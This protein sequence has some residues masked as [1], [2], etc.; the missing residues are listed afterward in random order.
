MTTR[1]RILEHLRSH[2]YRPLRT[3]RLAR[4][5]DIAEEEYGEFRDLV[6]RLIREG[7]I[8]VGAGGKLLPPE[9]GP[10]VKETRR[11][12]LQGR[13]SQSA[14]GFG[15]VSPAE[16][17]GP[18]GKE[19]LF[20]PAGDSLDAVTGD[21]VLAQVTRKTA[22]GYTGRVLEVLQRG[23]SRYVGTY[24]E[25]EAGP[26]V[27]PDGGVL[28][29]DFAA[30]DARS[31]GAQPK[32][33]VVFEVLRYGLQ[34]E[35]GEAVI[36]EVLGHRGDPGVDT[37]VVIRQFDLP[38][39]FSQEAL[40]E[41]RQAAGRL[42]E[43]ALEGRRDLARETVIT[44]DPA[45]ARDF[46]DA[47][48]LADGGDGSQVLGVH[49]ADVAFFVP[50][51][52]ALDRDARERG[53]SV[54]LPTTVLPMLPEV[55]SNGVCS[56]QEGR[57]RLTKSVFIRFGTE[58]EVLDVDLANSTIRSA[59]RLTY[60]QA[61]AAMDGKADGLPRRVADL[62]GRME[63]L[64]RTLLERRRRQGYLE[65]DL[66][67]VDLE[68]DAEGRVVDAHPEDTSFSHKVIEMF[69]VEANEAVA[70]ELASRGLEF[71]RRIHPPPD[72]E[73]AEDLKHFAT[74]IGYRLHDAADRHALQALLNA[75][76][77]KPEAYGIHLAVLRSL[78]R[79]EYSPRPEGHFALASDAYCHFTSP[80]RRYPD[81]TV[82]R[83][84]DEIVAGRAEKGR[85]GRHRKRPAPA[86]PGLGDLARHAS[87]T[88]QRAEAAERELTKI[89]LL[90][91][92]Q[93]RIGESYTGV[94]TGVQAFG[95]FVEIPNLLVDGLVHI[96]ALKDD[97]YK[98]DK[99]RWALVGQRRGRALRVGT[100]FA[101]RIAAVDIPRRQ[102]DLQPAEAERERRRPGKAP[103]KR[104]P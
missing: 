12:L 61:Q 103:P 95:M 83:L 82:H 53:T 74:S 92:L 7:E 84:F 46:D 3:R 28:L 22:R 69:M 60:E 104:G 14:R 75:V 42:N 45:D 81:L 63:R 35:P 73:A 34:S 66:P 54:Y 33:K 67:E 58:G 68:F 85:G 55:L 43:A 17:S 36:T 51:G 13:F 79:A 20:I 70:R 56:L 21:T 57:L 47:V 16:E 44:I 10:A 78:K 49:I 97:M 24:F 72:A 30:P 25:T 76:R 50:P 77:G 18:T 94:I 91:F 29:K 23:Q 11:G 62:L 15:F 41:A 5:F 99:R 64:A 19:D 32:D 31:S 86:D 2:H 8:V 38:D 26:V 96:S 93:T 89:K 39:E 6:K 48:S 100:E 88:E 9:R 90:E 102:L 98:F 4:F 59:Q 80:I 52:S 37:L 71:L 1:E 27:R 40:Q 101:V 87:A 65:L